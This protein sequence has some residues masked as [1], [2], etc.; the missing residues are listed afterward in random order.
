MRKRLLVGLLSAGLLAA[1]L[2]GVVAADEAFVCEDGMLYED[3]VLTVPVVVLEDTVC[4]F[5]D[6]VLK[7][8]VEVQD[9]GKLGFLSSSIKG[10]INVRDGAWAML[11]GS[12]LNGNIECYPEEWPSGVALWAGNQLKGN[13]SPKCYIEY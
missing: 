13:I 1:T 5:E 12:S 4:G 10:N 6:S 9:Y 2:P 7:A 3:M 8:S 11:M